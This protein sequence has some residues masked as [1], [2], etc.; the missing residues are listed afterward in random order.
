[1]TVDQLRVWVRE[2]RANAQTKIRDVSTQEWRLLAQ[3]PEFA[4]LTLP[5]SPTPPR[6]PGSARFGPSVE[7]ADPGP[8][9]RVPNYLVGAIL[10]T[11]CCCLP[12][13]IPAVVYAAQVNAKLDAGDYQGALDASDKAKKWCWGGFAAGLIGG[14]LYSLFAMMASGMAEF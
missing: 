13:G 3:I 9:Q 4:D 8:R 14:L 1:M 6:L 5:V 10:V 7:S 12:C 2:G 11:V